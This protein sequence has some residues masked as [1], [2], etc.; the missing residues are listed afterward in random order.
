MRGTAALIDQILSASQVSAGRRQ[1]DIE[2]ELRSHIEELVTSALERGLSAEQAE[3]EVLSR[4]GDPSEIGRCF[5]WVYR[6]DRRR[7]R[8]AAFL[9]ATLTVATCLAAAVLL[10]QAGLA[11]GFGFPITDVLTSP[12][13]KIEALDI[14]MTVAAY[15]GLTTLESLLNIRH[16][17]KS[18]LPLAMTPAI[19]LAVCTAVGWHV[20]FVLFGLVN[21]VF[22]RAIQLS[23]ASWFARVAIVMVFFLLAGLNSA[24]HWSASHIALIATCASWLAMGL[25]Y[26]IMTG[27]A[28]RVD[29]A[30]L[31]GLRRIQEGY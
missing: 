28:V 20:S 7:V 30:L 21:A 11:F 19:V 18:T 23:V 15:L 2:R 1:R 26:Q 25:G 16:F 14:L 24:L 10:L 29:A 17:K 31:N 8:V 13:T 6:H 27:L 5:S 12:H 3:R 22:F 4:F 9:L